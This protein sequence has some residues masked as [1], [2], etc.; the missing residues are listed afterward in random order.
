M[1]L[2][3]RSRALLWW[4][5]LYLPLIAIL[6]GAVI[7]FI[8][9]R[10]VLGALLYGFIG[11]GFYVFAAVF[12]VVII[13]IFQSFMNN[14]LQFLV[15]LGFSCCQQSTLLALGVVGM[16]SGWLIWHTFLMGILT[17][18]VVA[19]VGMAGFA[20]LALAQSRMPKAAS[21]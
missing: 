11:L 10:A 5:L 21:I 4:L 13:A 15:D 2:K 16:V 14:P 20:T 18:G 1:I 12:I 7:G 17:A 19:L 3:N 8:V 9:D 6:L